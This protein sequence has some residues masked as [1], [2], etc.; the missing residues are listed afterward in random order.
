MWWGRSTTRDLT[1][2][3]VMLWSS[4]PSF[5]HLFWD[6]WIVLCANLCSIWPCRKNLL[7]YLLVMRLECKYSNVYFYLIFC[8][9]NFNC[10][11]SYKIYTQDKIF[12]TSFPFVV[13]NV[14]TLSGFLVYSNLY[15]LRNL[16][17]LSTQKCF[18]N[19]PGS[20]RQLELNTADL[21]RSVEGL[22]GQKIALSLQG[23][24]GFL[25]QESHS[26]ASVIHIYIG[27]SFQ[28][29]IWNAE[30]VQRQTEMLGTPLSLMSTIECNIKQC[31]INC[32]FYC[33]QFDTLFDYILLRMRVISL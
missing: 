3:K 32:N 17:C 6:A 33:K 19:K 31:L 23:E 9:K 28:A 5:S 12:R 15:C 21:S 26:N 24:N 14:T 29:C 11:K 27:S 2:G 18:H 8:L 20:I 13:R 7:T 10:Y 4:S 22:Q 16:Y 25:C 30:F 1:S